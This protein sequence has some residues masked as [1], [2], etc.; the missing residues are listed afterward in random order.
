MRPTRNKP[1]DSARRVFQKHGTLRTSAALHAGIHPR[2][3]YALRDSGEIEQLARGLFRLA[4]LTSLTQPDLVTVAKR[5][6]RGVLCL[7]SA[8]AFHDLT[9]HV[10]HRVQIAIPRGTRKPTLANPP[11][12]AFPFSSRMFHAGVEHRRVDGISLKVYCAEKTLADMFKYRNKI[13][14]DV[15]VEGLRAY[16][17]RKGAR[18]QDVLKYARLCRVEKVLRPYLEAVA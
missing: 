1:F 8:L 14:S 6:P 11:L 2:T 13:G 12:E 7:I 17:R 3:L 18:F 15:A 5:V 4:K 9:T 16:A 10:P